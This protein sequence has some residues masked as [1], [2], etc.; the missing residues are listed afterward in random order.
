MVS[1]IHHVLKSQEGANG[2]HLPVSVT[3][4]LSA[5]E[6]TFIPR[7]KTGYQSRP[8]EIQ[9][10]TF[11][12]NAPGE[13][14]PPLP[15]IFFGH[16][17]LIEKIVLL[18]QRLTPT[19]LIGAGGISKTSIILTVLHDYRIKQRF[20][21][22]RWFIRCDQIPASHTHF[23]RQLSRIIGAR[24]ENPEDLTPLRR[25]LS[26]KEM[27]IVL[28]N[29]GSILDPQGSGA[30][31]IYTIVS[32]PTQLSNI[33]LCIT[34]RISTI[35]P[36]CETLEIPTLSMEA[37]RDTFH[38]I[39]KH[40]EQ[41][42]PIDNILEQLDFHPPL[43]HFTCHCCPV[44]QVGCQPTYQGV[45]ETANRSASRAALQEPRRRD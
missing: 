18:A 1:D 8:Q 25:C 13:L 22:N 35:P 16:E 36:D 6:Y 41:S 26:S 28:D 15:R 38:R 10:L 40:G 20:G 30:Q 4:V 21:D 7:L 43:R 33:C 44:Q 23:L 34:S 29:V 42:D 2:Q 45:E 31:D 14:P 32:E 27:L 24:I 11:L 39:Y 17:E 3:H 9:R 37:A 19:A 12:F 5:T